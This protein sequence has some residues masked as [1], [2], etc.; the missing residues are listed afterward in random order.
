MEPILFNAQKHHLQTICQ[1]TVKQA[2]QGEAFSQS[3]MAEW[4]ESDGLVD[5]YYGDLSSDQME[6]EVFDFLQKNDLLTVATYQKYLETQG[7]IKRKGH[8]AYLTLSDKTIMTLRLLYEPN[9]EGKVTRKSQDPRNFVHVHPARYS[10]NTV[11]VRA[12]TL[13]TAIVAF[14]LA[15]CRNNSPYNQE[16]VNEARSKLQLSPIPDIPSAISEMLGYLEKASQQLSHSTGEKHE[17]N[18][19]TENRQ[20]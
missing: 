19:D 9:E 16:I 8:Y 20:A 3:F 5:L 17:T 1:E 6:R 7:Q 12:N 15:V 13:K 14:F 10:P 2:K 4:A 11:R 18:L